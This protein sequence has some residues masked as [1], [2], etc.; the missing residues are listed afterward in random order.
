MEHHTPSQVRYRAALRSE[1][2]EPLEYQE[3]SGKG[4]SPAFDEKWNEGHTS[5]ACGIK[6]PTEVP[7][8]VPCAFIHQQ[9]SEAVEMTTWQESYS[10]AIEAMHE[11]L[12]AGASLDD[13]IR[14]LKQLRSDLG[15][16]TTSWGR[17]T[18]A[19]ARLRYLVRFG[20]VSPHKPSHQESPLERLMRQTSA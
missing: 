17:K 13:R 9:K 4:Y 10:A 11:T 6:T 18:W 7:R 14:A 20:Y 16:E 15:V 8:A 1:P 5:A 3:F 2:D 19:R 12:P